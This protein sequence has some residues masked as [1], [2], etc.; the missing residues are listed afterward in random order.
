MLLI[1]S[2]V[3]T[4]HTSSAA[5]RCCPRAKGCSSSLRSIRPRLYERR[6]VEAGLHVQ[7]GDVQR[8][9][10]DELAARLDDVAHQPG[11]DL[12]GDVGLG[13]LD[14]EQGAVGRD[15]AWFPRAGRRSSRP[16]PCSAGSA[17]PLRPA[18]RIASSSWVGRVTSAP[19]GSGAWRF[20]RA[21]LILLGFLGRLGRD[22]RAAQRDQPAR[23]R[24]RSSASRRRQAVQL[25][26][27]GRDQELVVD[28]VMVG[29]P[30]PQ[31]AQ[32]IIAVGADLA[33]PLAF[34]VDRAA[35]IR[36]CSDSASRAVAAPSC[37]SSAPVSA[38]ASMIAGS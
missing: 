9:F 37:G 14:L 33:G 28:D 22:R 27:L 7:I 1:E 25:A 38:S 13:D 19:R 30:A 5:G 16:G 3:G 21:A 35:A 20:G 15:R 11:E 26:R 4:G 10:L 12:V 6:A 18:A 17:R 23:R 29:D 32:H 36:R 24:H 31:P 8:I 2:E 34:L